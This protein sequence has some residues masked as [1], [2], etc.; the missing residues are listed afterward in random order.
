MIGWKDA[1]ARSCV[2]GLAL[3]AFI[4]AG[5][6]CARL[7]RMVK[8][9][10]AHPPES[11]KAERKFTNIRVALMKQAKRINLSSA[12]P[13]KI[14]D[15]QTK[16]NPDQVQLQADAQLVI[17]D[18][19]MMLAGRSLDSPVI[20]FVP[21]ANEYIRV[22]GKRYRGQI[23]IAL[24]DQQEGFLVVNYIPLEEYLL[25]VI[26]N[27][28]L[29]SWPEQ[30]LQAQAVAART[31]ALYKMSGRAQDRYDLDASVNNQVYGGLDSEKESTNQAVRAT[32]GWVALYEG[33]YIA[34]FYHSNCGGHTANVSDVWGSKMDY[35]CGTACGF[36]DNGPHFTWKNT[37]PQVELAARLRKHNL[38][39]NGECHLEL[40]GRDSGGRVTTVRIRHAGGTEEVKAAAFRMM[41]GPDVIR[42]TKF[43]LQEREKQFVFTG[44]GWGHGV[45]L[46]QEGAYGMA[47]SGYRFQ[48]ILQHFYPGIVLRKIRL[49]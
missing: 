24:T 44:K 1:I 29:S 23:E 5:A 28:V 14:Y 19:K 11:T 12:R 41:I 36:C 17:R 9:T 37:V 16:K 47:R 3:G 25:G 31:F 21:P 27:E 33:K 49:H 30:A 46:C 6:G 34:A 32:E 48:D 38:A 39:V 35:L 26:P 42:S 10:R 15:M 4:M 43:Y 2:C 7:G 20:R 8:P 22:N 40:I 18:G 13:V 45:G